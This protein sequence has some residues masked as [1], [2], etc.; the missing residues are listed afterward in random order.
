MF[1]TVLNP[2]RQKPALQ[3]SHKV[4][5]SQSNKSAQEAPEEDQDEELEPAPTDFRRHLVI[6]ILMLAVIVV[7]WILSWASGNS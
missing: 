6:F 1:R 4:Q 7:A 2:H 3:R 5:D